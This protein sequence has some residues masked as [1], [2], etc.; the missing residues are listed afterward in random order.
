MSEPEAVSRARK[1]LVTDGCEYNHYMC[2]V[3]RE[4]MLPDD[5]RCLAQERLSGLLAAY[6]ALAVT[7]REREAA[8][9]DAG[10]ASVRVFH[11]TNPYR[12]DENNDW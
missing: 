1:W 12:E 10:A 6:E 5:E 3:H 7:V 11:M 4:L 8:A 9:W 2:R